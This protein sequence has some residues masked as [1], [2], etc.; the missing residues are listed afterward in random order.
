MLLLR[1]LG[2]GSGAE[3]GAET[4]AEEEVLGQEQLGEVPARNNFAQ[5]KLWWRGAV[6]RQPALSLSVS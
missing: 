6:R 2:P 3:G 1:Q 5:R 4:Y